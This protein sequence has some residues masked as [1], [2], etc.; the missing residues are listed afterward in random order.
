MPTDTGADRVLGAL[1]R[2]GVDMLFGLCGDHVNPIFVAAARHGIRII[3]ARHESAAVHMADGYARV[4]GRPGVSVVTGGPGHTNSVTGIATAQAAGSPVIAISGSY[5]PEQAGRLAFQEMDQEGIVRPLAKQARLVSTGADIEPAVEEAFEAALSGRPGPVHLSLPLGVLSRPAE[6]ARGAAAG[7]SAP[8]AAPPRA[9]RA[10]DLLPDPR[11]VHDLLGRL[12]SAERPVLIVG[13]GA[14]WSGAAGALKLFVEAAHLPCF[15][16]DL[17]RGLLSDEHPLCFGYADPILN[18]AARAFQ[19]ADFV[20]IVGK[21]VD[22]RL[23]FG[24]PRVFHPQATL[25]QVDIRAEEFGRNRPVQLSIQADA[26]ATLEALAASIGGAAWPEKPWIEDLRRRRKVWRESWRE[27]EDSN[28]SPL[29]PLRVCREAREALNPDS[30]VVIDGGDWPQWPRMTLQARGP[31]QWMRLGALGTVGAGL[32]LAL[33]AC[34][35]RPGR[36]T[37]LFIGDGGMGFHLAELHTAARHNFDLSVIVGNDE[38]WG[39]EREIQSALYGAGAV[40]GCE[41]GPVRYDEAARAL[42]MRAERVER[43]ADLRAALERHLGGRGPALIDVR[44][45]KG[46]VSP[47]TAASIAAKRG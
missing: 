11:L 6:A 29:H 17:A 19:E 32:P 47:L 16:I 5:E 39:M 36:R 44:L 27:G 42:G 13:S 10:G 38:G 35:G 41:L 45:R 33:G 20:L 7:R 46:S 34:A 3:D 2:Q 30:A 23:G 24:G 40:T 26:R 1:R 25:A 43:A 28:E 4:T 21:R 14:F 15:T 22:F 8:S 31:G 9:D 18:A 12:G 37:V